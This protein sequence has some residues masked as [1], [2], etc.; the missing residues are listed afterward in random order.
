VAAPRNRA[1]HLRL[2]SRGGANKM[3][4]RTIR[5]WIIRGAILVMA[6]GIGFLAWQ[7]LKPNRLP[8]GIASGNGRIEAVEIDIAS[9]IPGRIKDIL[10]N[11]GDFVSADRCARLYGYRA[12]DCPPA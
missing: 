3:M 1:A 6:V 4:S 7:Y 5:F 8:P 12:S 2:L 11:E 10:V 9:K